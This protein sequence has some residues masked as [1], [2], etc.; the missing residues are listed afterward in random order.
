[1]NHQNQISV[2]FLLCVC[3][4]YEKEMQIA[5]VCECLERLGSTGT[6]NDSTRIS[7]FVAL[8]FVLQFQHAGA[9]MINLFL[10]FHTTNSGNSF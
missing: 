2:V 7:N 6:K 8:G 9:Y 1:M 5:Y 4:V 3:I 10:I